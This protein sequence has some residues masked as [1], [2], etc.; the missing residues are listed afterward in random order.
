MLKQDMLKFR[1]VHSAKS[2]IEM[3]PLLSKFCGFCLELNTLEKKFIAWDRIV[4]T[5]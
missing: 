2:S 4:G 3:H 1:W 5:G